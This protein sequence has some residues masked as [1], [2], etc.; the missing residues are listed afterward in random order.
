MYFAVGD[1]EGRIS[2][3]VITEKSMKYVSYALSSNSYDDIYAIDETIFDSRNQKLADYIKL[4]FSAS[5]H[6]IKRSEKSK[7]I[8][9]L[10]QSV[11][12]PMLVDNSIDLTEFSEFVE[13]I[14]Y[15]R[16]GC[17]SVGWCE[18]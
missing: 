8:S 11:F 1:T 12:E 2:A 6:G 18:I 4:H 3:H 14:V 5:L 10:V 15:T 7:F 9:F 17:G 13:C 16:R